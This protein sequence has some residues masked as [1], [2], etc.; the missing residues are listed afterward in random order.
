MQHFALV[1]PIGIP[2]KFNKGCIQSR[3]CIFTTTKE[4]QAEAGA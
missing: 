2:L 1:A 4:A 3:N